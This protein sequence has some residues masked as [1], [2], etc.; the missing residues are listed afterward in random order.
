MATVQ[1]ALQDRGSANVDLVNLVNT[2]ATW[3]ELLIELV[4]KNQLNPWD[5]DIIEIVDKY[6]D[7][8]KRM[9]VI[10]LRVPANIILA[11]AI[12]LRLKSSILSLEEELQESDAEE[13]PVSRPVIVVDGLNLRLRVPPKRRIS[14]KELI[15]ALDEAIKLKEQRIARINSPLSIPLEILTFDIEVESDRVY[16][17]LSKNLDR[18]RMT[19]FSHMSTLEEFKDVLLELFIPLLFLE[20]SGRVS[21]IQE[22]FFEEI[23]IAMPK[24]S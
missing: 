20:H 10:D 11:A 24:A 7:T 15:E 17:I 23:I 4:D 22:R 5:I 9:K 13:V 3:K 2:E 21:L 18:S 6:V 16:K 19:T 12:L 8:V 1:A 14:L